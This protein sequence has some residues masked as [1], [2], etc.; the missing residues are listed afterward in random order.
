M[1]LLWSQQSTKTKPSSL[2]QLLLMMHILQCLLPAVITLKQNWTDLMLYILF[3]FS[4]LVHSF[5]FSASFVRQAESLYT[6]SLQLNICL[7]HLIQEQLTVPLTAVLES[8]MGWETQALSNYHNKLGKKGSNINKI[9]D[10]DAKE[11]KSAFFFFASIPPGSNHIL[12]LFSCS[13]K[14]WYKSLPA[15]HDEFELS[16]KEKGC[17]LWWGDQKEII[18]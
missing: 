2:S 3:C 6:S 18:H 15:W 12:Q 4:Y 13:R 9:Y 7:H 1:Q 16:Y 14:I 8:E 17:W 11:I 5:F 10:K